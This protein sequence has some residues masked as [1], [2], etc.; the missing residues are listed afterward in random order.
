[1]QK[2]NQIWDIIYDEAQKIM[3]D[4][5]PFA[6]SELLITEI[7]RNQDALSY[8]LSLS[9]ITLDDY[10]II[11]DMIV[12][13]SRDV[14]G[15]GNCLYRSVYFGIIE[16]ALNNG[17][18]SLLVQ[19]KKEA[20]AAMAEKYYFFYNEQ[21]LKVVGNFTNEGIVL[22]DD[23]CALIDLEINSE[24][25]VGYLLKKINMETN[26]DYLFIYTMKMVVINYPD[27]T[28]RN[29]SKSEI[30]KWYS[31]ADIIYANCIAEFFNVG[32]IIKTEKTTTAMIKID[33]TKDKKL[34]KKN[35]KKKNLFIL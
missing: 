18:K 33:K 35:K 8:M 34:N 15:D 29:E 19:F 21:I 17:D 20:L 1:M 10:P 3:I 2:K 9:E 32:L 13:K 11:S 7:N 12:G 14:I 24:E 31:W 16:N 26:I 25:M 6:H 30:A 5:K 28:G 22:L 4:E 27:E 23:L